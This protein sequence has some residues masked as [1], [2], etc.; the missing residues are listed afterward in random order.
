DVG[1]GEILKEGGDL[2]IFAIGS[3]VYPSL[4][5]ASLLI[6]KGIYATVV[7]CRFVKP[8]DE[9]LISELASEIPFVLTVE[10]NVLDGGFGSGVIETLVNNE[11]SNVKIK[12]VGLPSVFVEHGHQDLLRNKYKLNAEGIA[13][14]AITL[15]EQQPHHAEPVHHIKS[16]KKGLFIGK[17]IKH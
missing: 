13:N 15:I 9:E 4:K 16:L 5:A 8:M 14:E 2:V 6:N 7:N 1:K 3:M 12:R 17:N 11:V 10:E